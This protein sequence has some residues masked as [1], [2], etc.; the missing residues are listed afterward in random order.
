MDSEEFEKIFE[1]QVAQ[2]REVLLTKAKEYATDDDRLH[3]FEAASALIGG[4]PEQALWG[5]AVKHLVSISDM[6]KDAEYHSEEKW[7]EKIGDAINYLIL[8][9]AQVFDTDNLRASV[10]P[11]RMISQT[12][13][14]PETGETRVH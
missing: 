8:L 10:N 5:F 11:S 12:F 7:D 2:S 3:N 13:M 6:V 9:R 4:T 1:R 14:T